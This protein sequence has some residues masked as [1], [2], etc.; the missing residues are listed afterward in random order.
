LSAQRTS[1]SACSLLGNRQVVLHL[2][3]SSSG[4]T[5]VVYEGMDNHQ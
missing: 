5:V 2:K 4:G 1:V 3:R